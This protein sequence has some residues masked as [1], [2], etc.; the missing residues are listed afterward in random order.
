MQNRTYLQ[1]YLVFST[2]SLSNIT[3]E[4]TKFYSN[5]ILVVL[6]IFLH[7]S[8]FAQKV[9]YVNGSGVVL[10]QS[11]FIATNHH[12]I[13][14]ATKI[15]IDVFNGS[16][17]KTYNAEVVKSDNDVDLS[18]LKIND[19]SFNGF[20]KIPYTLKSYNVNVGDKVF[21]MGYPQIQAQG[22]EVKVTDGIIS[23][24]TG[25]MGDNT[26]YQ[27]SVAIQPGNSGGPLFDSKGNLVGII[28]S[29]LNKDVFNSQNVNYAIK[30][31]YLSNLIDQLT[32]FPGLS[33]SNSL[34]ALAMPA[35]IKSLNPF[36]VLIRVE[37]PA[38]DLTSQ[39][40]KFYKILRG[41]SLDE[42]NQLFGFRGDRFRSDGSGS[43]RMDYYKWVFCGKDDI[44]I[45]C[46]FNSGELSLVSKSFDDNKCSNEVSKSNFMRIDVGM[47]YTD[48]VNILKSKGDCYRID[49]QE[50]NTVH[51]VRWYSCVKSDAKIEVWF[52]NGKVSLSNETN[53]K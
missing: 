50:Q 44:N 7:E 3:Q 15:E 27:T 5:I 31:S 8:A 16:V 23:S 40:E 37:I 14:N 21:A 41:T 38:C 48:V 19:P 22:T 53:L 17:K 36:V 11:G 39:N 35:I 33:E 6:C 2:N 18:I 4:I 20:G 30:V 13:K 47:S 49:Y 52:N 51:F 46:W 9:N 32:D 24:K 12:V 28:V 10:T 34:S 1:F 45:Q 26:L 25:V 43:Y 42:I 29:S